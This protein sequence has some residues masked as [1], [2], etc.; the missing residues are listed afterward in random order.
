M[1]IQIGLQNKQEIGFVF[2]DNSENIPC[3]AESGKEIN[4]AAQSIISSCAKAL[5]AAPKCA[6]NISLSVCSDTLKGIF[7][8]SAFS[9][10]ES[11]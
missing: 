1:T 8:R 10:A 7:S 6:V 2:I 11:P 5:V 3:D 4:L 9:L